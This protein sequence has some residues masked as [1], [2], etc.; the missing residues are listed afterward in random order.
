MERAGEG[1]RLKS[2]AEGSGA[3]KDLK[4]PNLYRP[5]RRILLAMMKANALLL[6]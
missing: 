4:M 5:P 1:E 3:E 2:D 6:L